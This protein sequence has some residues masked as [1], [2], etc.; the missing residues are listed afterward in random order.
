MIE[1]LFRALGI[2]GLLLIIIGIIAQRRK[3]RDEIYI[4]GGLMLLIYSIHIKD[5][6]FIILQIVFVIIAS[7]DLIKKRKSKI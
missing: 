6:I 4:L 5:I 7:Y 3:S 1:Y 2:I